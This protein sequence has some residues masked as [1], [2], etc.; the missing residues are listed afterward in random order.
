MKNALLVAVALATVG[1]Q[2]QTDALPAPVFHHLHLN[3]M[4]PS[5]PSQF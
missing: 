2:G 3:S 5:K 4:N 1:V